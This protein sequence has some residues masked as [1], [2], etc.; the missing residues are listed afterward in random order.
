MNTSNLDKILKQH[1]IWIDSEGKEGKMANLHGVDLREHNLQDADL[2]EV[3]LSGA[4]V[5]C[6]VIVHGNFARHPICLIN[7][8]NYLSVGCETHTVEYW[9]NHGKCLGKIAGYSHRE[10]E[11]Y[12]SEIMVIK[13]QRS[14]NDGDFHRDYD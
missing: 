4:A 13:L 6:N 5:D 7:N 14:C 1:R 12:I 11:R 10:I 8:T 9:I 2:N 3:D